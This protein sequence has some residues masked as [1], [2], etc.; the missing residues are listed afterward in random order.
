MSVYKD[1]NK[2]PGLTPND[3]YES[4]HDPMS[5]EPESRAAKALWEGASLEEMADFDGRIAEYEK[6]WKEGEKV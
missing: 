3:P 2:Y 1:G 6:N 4:A 5:K